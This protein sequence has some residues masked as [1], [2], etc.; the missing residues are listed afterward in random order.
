MS[1]YIGFLRSWEV[2]RWV[3]N[4]LNRARREWWAVHIEAWQRSGLSQRRYCRDHHL[5]SET[6]PRWLRAITDAETAKLRAQCA[7]I[8]AEAER[9]ERRRQRKG[10]LMR[11]GDKRS[12]AVQAFWAM[13]DVLTR[14]ID[15]HPVNRLDELLPWAWKSGI[16]VKA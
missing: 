4:I 8:L 5:A 11:S 7:K 15:G 14:M 6:F 12:R 10:P 13:H 2:L 9:D 3:R 16:H 1:F